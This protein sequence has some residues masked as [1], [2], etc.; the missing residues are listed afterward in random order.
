LNRFVLTLVGTLVA[1]LS[2]A[3]A[4][5]PSIQPGEWMVVSKTVVNGAPTPPTTRP[6]CLTPEQTGNLSK[7]FGPQVGT[8]N[9]TCAEPVLETTARTLSWKLECRGQMD[10]DIQASFEFDSPTRYTAKVTSK[11]WMAGSLM[12]DVKSEVEGERVGECR[13]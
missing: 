3:A 4:E 11:A 9:S 13:Q 5:M 12:S 8:V 10:M 2:P 6:R 7:T 1:T